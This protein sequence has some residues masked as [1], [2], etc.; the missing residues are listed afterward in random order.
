MDHLRRGVRARYD[1]AVKAKLIDPALS[2]TQ[3]YRT[4]RAL[5]DGLGNSDRGNLVEYWYQQR[6][7]PDAT[8]HVGY[9]VL[10]TSGAHQGAREQR[11]ADLRRGREITEIKDNRTTKTRLVL[12]RQVIVRRPSTM[13]FWRGME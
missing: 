5:L 1:R 13:P 12:H 4:M 3:S 8:A 11:V 9:D 6:H 7:A 2:D 10:R